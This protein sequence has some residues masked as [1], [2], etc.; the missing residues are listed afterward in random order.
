MRIIRFLTEVNTETGFTLIG[1][2]DHC[3]IKRVSRQMKVLWMR[4]EYM[5]MVWGKTL[6]SASQY[7]SKECPVEN[8][9]GPLL[10]LW[11][12]S[13]VWID[14]SN[15]SIPT[16]GKHHRYRSGVFPLY[17]LIEVI[18]Q[19]QLQEQKHLTEKLWLNHF[20]ITWSTEMVRVVGHKG[21]EGNEIGDWDLNQHPRKGCQKLD[22]QW[23]QRST[24]GL[25][26]VNKDPL[27]KQLGS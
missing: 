6:T 9:N 10:Y 13:P 22:K 12:F 15:K 7:A 26:H 11:C 19:L 24:T 8:F 16:G 14:W 3:V 17:G 2:G 1:Q 23:P 18:K 20:P 21:N 25:K 27:P 5:V 4:Y